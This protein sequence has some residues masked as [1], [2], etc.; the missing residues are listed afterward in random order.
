MRLTDSERSAVGD[1]SGVVGGTGIPPLSHAQ[2]ARATFQTAPLLVNLSSYLQG[3]Q[4]PFRS[5]AWSSHLI[6]ARPRSA[7]PQSTLNFGVFDWRNTKMI[8][9]DTREM[10]EVGKAAAQRCLGN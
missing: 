4:P 9:K 6:E 2:N 10:T 1:G 3:W 7:A 8:T 5:Y